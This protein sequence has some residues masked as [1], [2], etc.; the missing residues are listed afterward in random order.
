M[1]QD[2]LPESDHV[3]MLVDLLLRFPEIYTISL[4]LP[5][6]S[7]HLSYM[8]RRELNLEEYASLQRHLQEN[9]ATFCYL[10]RCQERCPFKISHKN[11]CGLTR[12]QLTLGCV[13]FLDEL[14]S[15][16]TALMRDLFPEELAAEKR[17]A[18]EHRWPEDDFIGELSS[19]GKDP[20]RRGNRLTA[21]R[22]SGKVYIFD[23]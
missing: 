6:C 18:A 17:S 8:I 16:L 19:P 1:L 4:N 21:F 22:D 7:C 20:Q 15:L 23:Q 3:H 12:L 9:M 10:N 11:H 2:P 5:S 14:I 13:S